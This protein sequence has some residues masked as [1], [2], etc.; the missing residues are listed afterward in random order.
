MGRVDGAHS[1]RFMAEGNM[2]LLELR[3]SGIRVLADPWLVDNL[4]FWEQPWLFSGKIFIWFFASSSDLPSQFFSYLHWSCAVVCTSIILTWW[5]IISSYQGCRK[6]TATNYWRRSVV[7]RRQ[8]CAFRVLQQNPKPYLLTVNGAQKTG[9]W[10]QGL[11]QKWLES[12]QCSLW[13]MTD[14]LCILCNC[15]SLWI[16]T[17]GLI[18]WR[19]DMGEC[20]QC[21]CGLHISGSFWHH[22]VNLK[23]LARKLWK[24]CSCPLKIDMLLCLLL[25]PLGD[26]L[27]SLE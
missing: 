12:Y 27:F 11:Q 23:W 7:H 10:V 13:R 2:W 19:F 21:G 14:Y 6:Q 16:S 26:M 22:V 5:R 17:K 24:I 18:S 9:L 4:I 8:D 20:E 1:F 15:R 25:L 3:A